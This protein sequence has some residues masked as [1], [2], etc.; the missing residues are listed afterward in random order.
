MRALLVTVVAVLLLAS[1]C[2]DSDDGD[3]AATEPDAT[4]TTSTGPAT[5]SSTPDPSEGTSTTTS[6]TA[7][8]LQFSVD[9]LTGGSN[10]PVDFTCDGANETPAV[11]IEG[12]PSGVEELAL[13]VDDPDAP[14]DSPFVHWAV[15][16]IG[17]DTS[18]VT[19]GDASL[20]YGVNDA[21]TD[22]WSGPCPPPGD[23]LHTYRWKLFGL[24]AATDLEP[25]LDGRA[26]EAAIADTI[27]T[28]SLL[29]ASYERAT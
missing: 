29:I 15:Y 26:L 7:V 3:E 18:T 20:T 19:D 1:G 16:G 13:V 25:G 27:V 9:G 22:A 6:A 24:S 23:G 21:G 11:T 5:S 10:V 8:S 2:S 4:A 12:V 17:T 14:T 28:D